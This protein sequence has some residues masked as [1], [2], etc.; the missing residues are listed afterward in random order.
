MQGLVSEPFQLAPSQDLNLGDLISTPAGKVVVEL[1]RWPGTQS[2]DVAVRLFDVATD[3]Q[4]LQRDVRGTHAIFDNVVP[5][6][7][8]VELEGRIGLTVVDNEG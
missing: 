2:C 8:C 1:D 6:S 3:I 4:Y 5:G 7:Y